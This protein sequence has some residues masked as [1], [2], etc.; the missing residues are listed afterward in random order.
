EDGGGETAV[1]SP[2]TSAT[3]QPNTCPFDAAGDIE[4]GTLTVPEDR[5]DANS[6]AIQLAVAIV[7][8]PNGGSAAPVVYL[9]GGPGGSALDDYTA[10]PE[11]WNYPFL[12]NRDLI[13]LDQRGTGYS[14]PT[15]DCPEFTEADE[16]DNPDALCYDRLTADGINLDAYNTREN[17]A[18][19][20]ALRT[21]LG[22]GEWDLLGISYGTR[23]ALEVMRSRPEG[24]RAIILDS[25]FPPNADT[26]VEEIY[27]VT[28]ALAEL[29]A[30]CEQDAY[31]REEYPDLEAVFLET[32]QRLNDDDMAEIYGDDLVFALSSAFSDTE[33][34]PLLPYVI[35]EVAYDNYDALD[36]ISADAGFVRPRYQDDGADRS[37]SEG[38]YNS[39]ICHDEFATGDYE[40]VET[41]VLGTIP[42]E[43]EGALLQNTFDQ[44]QLCEMWNPKTSVDNTAVSSSIPTLILV[45]QYDVATPP[46]WA[47]LTAKTLSNSYLFEFP[48]AGHSLLSSVDCAISI[49]DAFLAEPGVE[50]NGNCLNDIEWPYF[51]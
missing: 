2:T 34:I 50:P 21:A 9:A 25:P 51:E 13:L 8:A 33:L 20:A 27:S 15:L 49:T 39:V 11:S 44:E 14:V 36:E 42:T 24:V 30:D 18:D 32:V 1:S 6:P 16:R 35:Y 19:V 3:F 40:R 5:S 4:C 22:I 31:C 43:L 45:G 37:D 12:Q 29:F 47:Q 26:P 10:D 41:A 17:A 38:M 46:R 7:H 23:L 48:G 28:D